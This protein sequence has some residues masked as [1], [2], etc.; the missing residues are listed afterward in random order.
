MGPHPFRNNAPLLNLN[1]NYE[2]LRFK[3]YKLCAKVEIFENT[4]KYF[5]FLKKFFLYKD[6]NSLNR[7]QF[8]IKYVIFLFEENLSK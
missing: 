6:R 4:F 1:L 7:L 3:N 5:L 2:K 8:I